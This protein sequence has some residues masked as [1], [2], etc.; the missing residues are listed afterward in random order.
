MIIKSQL[1]FTTVDYG[2]S[3]G[4]G[5]GHS[6]WNFF[7]W[8]GSL[9]AGSKQADSWRWTEDTLLKQSGT[10]EEREKQGYHGLETELMFG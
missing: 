3:H 2:R 4:G 10:L 7:T 8:L 9:D 6:L 5:G 1:G